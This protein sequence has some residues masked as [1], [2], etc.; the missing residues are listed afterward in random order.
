MV[1]RS[2]EA[3]Y[4]D[5]YRVTEALVDRY[6]DLLSG[7]E[8]VRR[9]STQ[10]PSGPGD[11]DLDRRLREIDVRYFSNGGNTTG[12]YRC[13]SRIGCMTAYGTLSC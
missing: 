11:P 6:D 3:V 7:T 12:A 9:S 2:V 10:W 8:T 1:R 13:P 5:P 4:A